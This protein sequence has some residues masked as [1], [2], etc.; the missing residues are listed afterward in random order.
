MWRHDRQRRQ[1][2]SHYEIVEDDNGDGCKM[3]AAR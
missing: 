2:F 3:M 1:N